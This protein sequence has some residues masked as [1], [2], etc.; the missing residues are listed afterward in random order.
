MRRL[1]LT[2]FLLGALIPLPA[3]ESSSLFNGRWELLPERSSALDGWTDM[4]L[5]FEVEG[6]RVN[7]T[8][9]MRWRSTRVVETNSVIAGDTVEVPDFF[10]V[11]QRHMAVYPHRGAASTVSADWLDDDRTLKVKANVPVEVSQGLAMM[12]IE[13]EY[14]LGVGDDTLTVIEL[15]ST[16]NNPLVYRF[17]KLPAGD[18]SRP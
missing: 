2:L 13:C 12:R 15:H 18:S 14:R 4:H 6:D 17:R 10:R 3:S 16:R 5:V 9:D 7:I 1:L 11:E 8:H